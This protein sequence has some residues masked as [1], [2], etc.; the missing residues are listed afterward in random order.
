MCNNKLATVAQVKAGEVIF[1]FRRWLYDDLA[2][3]WNQ[4]WYDVL[5][6]SLS[7]EPDKIS[8]IFEKSGRFSV[9][10]VYN[11]LTKNDS[12]LYHKKIWKGKIPPKIKFFMWLLTNDAILTR[13]NLVKRKWVGDPSCLFCDS[14]ESV[15][16]LFFQ[17]PVAKVIWSIV[18]KCFG[19]TNI[20][21]N[22]QQCWKWC[23]YWLPHGENYYLWGIAAICWASWKN[24]N[25][26]CF[27]KHLIK[28]PL[29]IICH[30]CALVK[31]WAGLFPSIDKEKLEEG[32]ATMLRLAKELLASQRK[33]RE[34]GRRLDSRDQNEDDDEPV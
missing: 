13:D 14:A 28:D 15:D 12:G 23:E 20:P 3:C 8:W 9:K 25:K 32:A 11:G 30:A 29:E 10:S 19:A 18:A 22:L 7:N 5:N 34:E 6:F 26:A 4:I 1:Q 31:Y 2:T 21:C 16:H 24:R 27:E 33:N 17:C